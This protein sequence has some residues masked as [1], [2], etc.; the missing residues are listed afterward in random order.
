ML[1]P[2]LATPNPYEAADEFASN[3]WAIAFATP[4]DSDDRMAVVELEG[5]QVML[6][7]DTEEFLTPEAHPFRGAGVEFYV[8]V[9]AD[10]IESVHG[11]HT[12]PDPIEEKAWGVRAFHVEL[13][14]YRFLIATTNE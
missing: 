6:G 3:G 14:G 10:R 13:A 9:P 2:I 8:E 12:S 5:A 11:A 7:V 4:E 1:T